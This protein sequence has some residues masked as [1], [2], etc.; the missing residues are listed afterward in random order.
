MSRDKPSPLALSKSWSTELMSIMKWVLFY[1]THL[2]Y[3]QYLITGSN[4]SATVYQLSYW[5]FLATGLTVKAQ[6]KP[7][8][9]RRMTSWF[10]TTSVPSS[11]S[12]LSSLT[13]HV[14]SLSFALPPK[15][16]FR[17]FSLF[18]YYRLLGV[19]GKV[20]YIETVTVYYMAIV[21]GTDFVTWK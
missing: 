3:C 7:A 11:S 15:G 19:G 21:T 2:H 12:T 20:Y 8:V 5:G 1:I 13:S 9:A 4:N 10:W 18:F 17:L 6:R 14:P 16:N